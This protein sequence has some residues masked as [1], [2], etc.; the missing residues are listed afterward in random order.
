MAFDSLFSVK[1]SLSCRLIAAS[2]LFGI[3]G[4]LIAGCSKKEAAVAPPPAPVAA[5]PAAD[6]S[7][8]N[9]QP[10]V[11]SPAVQYT[12]ADMQSAMKTKDYDKAAAVMISLQRPAVP[13]TPAQSAV[14][15]D[16]MRAFQRELAGALASGDPKAKA[17]AERLRQAAMSR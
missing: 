7:A 6:N 14:V 10:P 16:Q 11:A 8:D 17:A 15:Q 12:A 13:L 3:I 2:A 9:S 4:L 5:A 1:L